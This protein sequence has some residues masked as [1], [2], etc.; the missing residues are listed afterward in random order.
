MT[1]SMTVAQTIREQIGSGALFM[2]GAKNLL[3]G[4]NSLWFGI[5]RNAKS[6]THVKVLLDPTDTYTV[7]FWRVRKGIGKVVTSEDGIYFDSLCECLSRGTGM[8]TG[9]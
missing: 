3:G 6:I 1:N 9:L 8:A 7:Q 4:P 5:G 2:M